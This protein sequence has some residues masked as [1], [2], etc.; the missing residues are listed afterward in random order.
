MVPRLRERDKHHKRLAKGRASMPLSHKHIDE[1]TGDEQEE[2]KKALHA[3]R[4]M[5]KY[6]KSLTAACKEVGLKSFKKAKSH[7]YGALTKRKG[8]FRIRTKIHHIEHKLLIYTNGMRKTIMLDDS[9]FDTYISNYFTDI[10]TGS[11]KG[12]LSTLNQYDKSIVDADGRSYK[13]E[14]RQDVIVDLEMGMENIEFGD[15][16]RD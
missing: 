16:Y 4:L 11:K 14:T 9:R 13:L 6:R 8:R 1:L 12:D 3:L 7:L 10:K 2:R 5:R 15:W